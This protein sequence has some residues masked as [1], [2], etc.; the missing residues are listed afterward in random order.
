MK[1]IWVEFTMGV[2]IKIS[3]TLHDKMEEAQGSEDPDDLKS[4]AEDTVVSALNLI[5]HEY[6]I[7][8]VH[9]VD[10]AEV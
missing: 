2:S 6:S 7:S 4:L 9:S 1:T 5:G 3:D 8:G 10:L